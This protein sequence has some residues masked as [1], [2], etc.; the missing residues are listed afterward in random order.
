MVDILQ[1]LH[2]YIMDADRIPFAIAAFF[3]TVVIGPI[4]GPVAGNA[5]PLLWV[6]YDWGFGSLGERM[7]RLARGSK[8]LKFRGLLY[9]SV[10]L[11]FTLAFSIV[12][13]SMNHY[14]MELFLVCACMTTGSLWYVLLKLYFALEKD[15][16][17]DDSYFSLAR[18]SR[19]DLNSTDQF[20]MTRVGLGQIG[21]AFDKGMVAPVIWYLIAGLPGMLVFSCLA[22]IAWRFGKSGFSK[23]FGV[24]PMQLERLMGMI[25]SLF[26]GFIMSAA[27]AMTPSANIK[28]AIVQW[29]SRQGKAPYEEGGPVLSALAWPL[30]VSLG[31]PV[32]D[33]T[34]SSLQKKWIGPKD[35]SAQISHKHLKRGL[36]ISLTSHLLFMVILLAVY[37]YT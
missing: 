3:I 31:G 30:E 24:V 36:A 25:P 32:Q 35:A 34:G 12:I 11:L 33:V 27:A 7:D 5:N 4:S 16:E 1:E 10:L 28:E 37:I 17:L 18:S 26:A 2:G 23:G 9:V 15:E 22:F 19:I 20:G 6:V 14:L 13:E 21:V 8:D 29:W